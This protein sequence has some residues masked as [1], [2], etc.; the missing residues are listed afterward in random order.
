[1]KS[2]ESR[3]SPHYF[4][5]HH[6]VVTLSGRME[7]VDRLDGRAD[8]G[9][10]TERRDRAAYVVVDRLRD[11]DDFQS[12]LHQLQRDTQ[13]AVA[14]NCNERV[15]SCFLDVCYELPGTIL[16]Y[17]AAIVLQHRKVKRV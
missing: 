12:A 4:E 15:D 8:G 1:M 3:V 6:P 10:E 11:A 7:L 13:C 16:G 9:I 2:D 17:V 14:A 5:H